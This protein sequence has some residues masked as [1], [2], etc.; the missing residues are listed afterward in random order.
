M[1]MILFSD[2][3]GSNLLMRKYTEKNIK[4]GLD[5]FIFLGDGLDGAK[6][7]AEEFSLPFYGVV[8]NC[9]AFSSAPIDLLIPCGRTNIF[10]THGHKYGVKHSPDILLSYARAKSADIALFG[11]THER[12]S[13]YFPAEGAKRAVWLFNPGSISN[14]HEDLPSFGILEVRHNDVYL[15]HGDADSYR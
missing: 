9:D 3:H 8:G 10:I 1:R 12:Y 5:G 7:V 11:H 6:Q 4:A 2:S 13:E 15:S 14:P